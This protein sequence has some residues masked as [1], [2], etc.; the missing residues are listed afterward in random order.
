ML[1]L[2]LA[3]LVAVFAIA[4]KVLMWMVPL[5]GYFLP[6]FIAMLRKHPKRGAV[7][8]L[9]LCL[10]WTFLGWIVALIWSFSGESRTAAA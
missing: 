8:L 6:T 3:V 5:M 9:N 4:L 1:S 7:F 2:L 10:G